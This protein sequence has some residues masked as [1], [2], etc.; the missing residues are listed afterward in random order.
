MRT[1]ALTIEYIWANGLIMKTTKY[2]LRDIRQFFG[3]S[4]RSPLWTNFELCWRTR[5]AVRFFASWR[6]FNI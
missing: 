6:S 5:L 1:L 2:S 3:A 4:I